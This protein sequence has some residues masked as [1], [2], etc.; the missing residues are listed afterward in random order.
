MSNA[1]AF[2]IALGIATAGHMIADAVRHP[3]PVH[4]EQ[5]TTIRFVDEKNHGPR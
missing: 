5:V 4:V 3:G 1:G 2:L